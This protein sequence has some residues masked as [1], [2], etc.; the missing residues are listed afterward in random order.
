MNRLLI[1]SIN[2]FRMVF[3]DPF[4]KGLVLAPLVIAILAVFIIP[5]LNSRFP[6]LIDYYPVILMATSTQAATMFGF[7]NG[8]IFL[9]EKDENVFM[10]LKTMPVSARL[11]L[12]SRLGLGILVSIIFSWSIFHFAPLV[13]MNGLQ[14][15][16]LALQFSLLSPLLALSVAVFAKNKVEGLAQYKIYNLFVILPL[17][18]YFLDHKALHLLGIFPSY[19]SFRSIEMIASGGAFWTYFGI[20]CLVYLLFLY[21]LVRLFEDKVF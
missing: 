12:V 6:V 19:W 11:F 14:E 20:G 13:D 7:I 16:A 1:L 10:A 2:D 8:F 21:I 5:F 15:I 18:I 9:E 3:R 17:I 4:L